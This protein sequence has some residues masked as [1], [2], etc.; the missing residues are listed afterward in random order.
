MAT[1]EDIR[2]AAR[3]L[4]GAAEVDWNGSP[5]WQV[6]SKG[7]VHLFKGRVLMKLEKNHQELLFE[8]RPDVFTPFTAGA[9]RWSWVEIDEL[10]AEEVGELVREAWTQVVP[11]K[12]SRAHF[13]SP[14][15]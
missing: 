3:P 6:G 2:A 1:W 12:V 4:P 15:A 10:D 5:N 11:K 7:F 8:A 13:S 14:P 9:M